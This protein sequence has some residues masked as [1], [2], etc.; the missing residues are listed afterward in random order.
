VQITQRSPYEAET[1]VHD[2]GIYAQDRWTIGRLTANL[3]VRYDFYRTSYPTQTL[4]PN[5]FTPN[6]NV[7]FQAG[8][9]ASFNDV[10]PKLGVAYDLFGNG[11]TALK[12]SLSKYVQQMSYGGT[13]GESATP[14]VRTVQTV[15]RAWTDRNTNFIPDCDL[16]NL[17]ANGECDIVNNLAYGN[18]IPSTTYDPA[19]LSGWGKRGYNWETSVGIPTAIDAERVG[20]R[21]IFPSLVW[22]LSRHRQSEPCRL[23]ISRSSASRRQL[24][25]GFQAAAVSA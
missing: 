21:W 14:A 13:F 10:T 16:L 19:T 17:Q 5:A 4:G 25:H 1:H 24:I 6:R 9:V 12:A 11:K 22:Q 8:K 2:G 18:P 3:G 7:T 20:R 23:R 15:T